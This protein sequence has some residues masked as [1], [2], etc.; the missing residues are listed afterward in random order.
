MDQSSC[1][2]DVGRGRRGMLHVEEGLGRGRE[3]EREREGVSSAAGAGVLVNDDG[4]DD[5]DTCVML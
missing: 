4:S 2:M 5:N 3:D 1:I